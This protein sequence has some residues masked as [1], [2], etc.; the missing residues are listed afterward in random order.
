MNEARV[1]ALYLPQFHP[2]KENNEIW[3]KGF[4]EW[5]NVAK[6]KPLFRGHYQPQIPA[7]LG[8]Y[9]LRLPQVREEQ[10]KLAK[11]YGIEG[12]CYWHYWFGNGKRILD[13]PF[14]EV[15]KTGK[16][17]FPFCLA[18]AN[19]S[20]STS[21][22]NNAQKEKKDIE[23]L[24][25]EYLGVKDYTEHFYA[26]LPAFKDKRYIYVDDKP[27]FTIFNVS[28]IPEKEL[29]LFINTWNKLAIKNGLKGIHFVA[30]VESVEKLTD[31]N[32][33]KRIK[34][35]YEK[36]YDRYLNM[37]FDAI[38]A[39]NRRRAE[40]LSNGI[41]NKFIK[42]S[43]YHVFKIRM[44]DRY[45]YSDIV[46]NFH[47]TKESEENVYPMIIPR[48]D[49]TPRQGK[50]ADIYY[51]STPEL[52][53]KHVRNAMNLIKKKKEQHKIIYLQAWNEWGE[54]N[55]MEP[56]IKFGHKYLEALKKGMEEN[57]L[58]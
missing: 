37:G 39:D 58:C 45:N 34:K 47:T 28:L 51:R 53:E 21:T 16:P 23:F 18:W 33:I 54:G 30:R 6:A 56:D 17:D 4:T 12:F 20:W 26:V 27:I 36:E 19:H 2:V 32:V 15:L 14:N 55:Y 7:D 42:R 25:Q 8:F 44:L 22:W 11:Q 52:F 35:D 43:L 41:L 1:I 31:K 50:L 24:K 9:D 13:M 49:R 46:N 48:W 29:R 57:N 3:G 38:W 5:T 40:I 10:A